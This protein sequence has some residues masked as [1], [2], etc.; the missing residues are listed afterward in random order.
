[1]A[2]G[3]IF[4]TYI[5]QSSVVFHWH[6]LGCF[7]CVFGLVLFSWYLGFI[8][9]LCRFLCKPVGVIRFFWT[10]NFSRDLVPGICV[11]FRICMCS[12]WY[13]LIFTVFV[14]TLLYP[15]I[16]PLPI[17]YLPV[18]SSFYLLLSW[19]SFEHCS[20]ESW[21]RHSN[22]WAMELWMNV[23]RVAINRRLMCGQNCNS[24][25]SVFIPNLRFIYMTYFGNLLF[26]C[27]ERVWTDNLWITNPLL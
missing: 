3:F 1:M 16:Y 14:P 10:C 19:V 23:A 11:L 22:H 6:S 2:F 7:G 24:V 4:G 21:I 17:D 27:Q 9:G 5:F 18:Y 25:K 12:T 13:L 8:L 26:F 20:A 15:S